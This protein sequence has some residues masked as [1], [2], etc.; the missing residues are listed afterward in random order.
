[1]TSRRHLAVVEP[2]LEELALEANRRHALCREAAWAIVEH[3]LT[4]G[5]ALLAAK[6]QVQHGAWLPW[7]AANFD[8]SERT[9]QL[10]MT[11]AANPQ[12]VADLK[13]PDLSLRG[14]VRRLKRVERQQKAERRR[15]QPLEP[16]SKLGEIETRH[17]DF[18]EALAD[19]DGEVDAIVTDPP[20][21]AASLPVV[22]SL[23]AFAA[24]ALRPSGALVA[25][26]GQLHI[27]EALRRLDA[28]LSFR[29]LG[30]YLADGP[31]TTRIQAARVGSSWKPLLIYSRPGPEPPQ[32]LLEDVIVS[33]AR[34][35][36]E[37]DWQQSVE[38]AVAL[39]E[40]VTRPG[41]LVVDPFLGSGTTALA[42]VQLG[43]RFIGCDVD[44]A[45]VA[46]ARERLQTWS[47]S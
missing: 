40:R 13:A 35:K 41:A 8:G 4:A 5:E 22:S 34:A 11:V 28:E 30:C 9:A 7:L 44:A 10:Y 21:S 1:M 46:T 23:G 18:V 29:W 45:A 38:G 3:A 2:P 42:C 32:W 24:R 39:V 33:P 16:T 26:F 17:G 43:R 31:R 20:Y 14:I 15:A 47:L 37:H 19:L 25:M 6:A 12:R 36:G 27:A